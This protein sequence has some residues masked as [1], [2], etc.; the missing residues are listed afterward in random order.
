M[1]ESHWKTHTQKKKKEIGI[2]LYMGN[3]DKFNMNSAR[4]DTGNY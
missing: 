3:L 4:F 2:V 1:S